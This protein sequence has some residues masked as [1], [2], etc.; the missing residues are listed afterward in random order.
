MEVRR[1]WT[2]GLSAPRFQQPGRLQRHGFKSYSQT[3]EDGIIAEILRRLG[4]GVPRRFVEFGVENGLECNTLRLLLQGWNGLW[5]EGAQT[6]CTEID[7]RFPQYLSDRTLVLEQAMVT[8]GNIDKLLAANK[9]EGEIGVLSIDIDGNDLWVWQA[10]EAVR[11]AVVVIEYNAAWTPPLSVVQ[12][13]REDRSWDG[14]N[15]FGASL[16]ALT[17]V[18]NQKGFNLVGC[19]YSGV[20][21]FFVRAELAGALFHGPYTA[22]EH[23]EPARYWLRFLRSGHQPGMGPLVTV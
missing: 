20:N 14:S 5:I 15:Y 9:V 17:R 10:I 8:R 18:G 21:A 11:P 13:Y 19:S 1:D 12:E 2:D 3:D 16:E 6:H 22:E 4:A 7:T 23:Y